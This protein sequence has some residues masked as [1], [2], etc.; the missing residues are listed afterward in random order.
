M[1]LTTILERLDERRGLSNKFYFLDP[2]SLISEKN[3]VCDYF[4][5]FLSHTTTG[6]TNPALLYNVE[7]SAPLVAVKGIS[8]Y[9]KFP[10]ALPPGGVEDRSNDDLQNAIE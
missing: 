2:V 9:Q 7:D 6:R 3:P 10:C 4:S 5:W 1:L 8:P